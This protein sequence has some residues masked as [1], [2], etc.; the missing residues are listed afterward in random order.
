MQNGNVALELAAQYGHGE[1]VGVLIGA[2][3]AA[4]H[5]VNACLGRVISVY[6]REQVRNPRGL[7][8]SADRERRQTM[9]MCASQCGHEESVRALIEKGASLE[10]VNEVP[11]PT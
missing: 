2:G 4:G 11:I 1:V 5:D 9:L 6:A 7:L 3:M 8:L 10:A